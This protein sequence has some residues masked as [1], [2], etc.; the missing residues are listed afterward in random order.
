VLIVGFT[1]MRTAVEIPW[2]HLLAL[3]L[4]VP[5]TGSALAWVFT[6]AAL[7]MSRRGLLA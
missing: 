2:L 5:L 3:M 7:P 4:A 1:D 6:R